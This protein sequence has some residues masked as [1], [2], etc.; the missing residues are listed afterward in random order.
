MYRLVHITTLPQTAA[1]FLQGQL[2]WMREQGFEVTLVSSPGEQLSEFADTQ[3]AA[4][5]ALPMHRG[6]SPVRDTLAIRRLTSVL[7]EIAP[8]VVHAHTPKAGLVG[9][10]AARLADVPVRIYQQHGLRFET[11]RGWRRR[12]LKSAERMTCRLAHRVICV[13]PSLRQKGL[14][15]GLYHADRAVVIGHGSANGLDAEAFVGREDL[16]RLR[17]QT[18]QRLGIPSGAICLGFVGRVVRDKGVVELHAAWRQLRG[19]FPDLHLLVVG[20]FEAGDAIPSAVRRDLNGDPRVH[21]TGLDWNTRGYYAA[22]DVFTLP[23]HREGLPQVLLEASVMGLPVVSCQATGCVDAVVPG[24][25]GTL[26][27]VGDWQAL[28]GALAR[29]VADPEL[30]QRHGEGGRQWVRSR[31][32]P[33]SMWRGL[34]REYECLLRQQVP[35]PT[36]IRR[37]SRAAA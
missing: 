16:E 12:V 7:R 33:E 29:Y 3:G 6:F 10:A 18:R 5:H 2:R 27:P 22:T 14:A 13:S 36:G 26:V 37:Q 31:F 17:Q 8:H 35:E 23:S 9:M 21:L 25:T 28:A 11:S 32:A 4:W 20:P 19:E 24:R 30:R 15:E 1:S 34:L